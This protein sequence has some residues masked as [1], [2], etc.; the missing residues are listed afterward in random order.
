MCVSAKSPTTKFGVY[1][2]K[3]KSKIFIFGLVLI[4]NVSLITCPMF[5]IQD[6]AGN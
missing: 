4:R 2:K 5:L 1:E 6:V 3:D